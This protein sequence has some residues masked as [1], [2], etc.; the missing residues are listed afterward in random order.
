MI[1]RLVDFII[2]ILYLFR[3]YTILAPYQKGVKIRF[4]KFNKALE[5]GPVFFLPFKLDQVLIENAVTETLNTSPQSLTTKDGVGVVISS[6]VTF[7]IEDIKTFLLCVEGRNNVVEDCTYGAISSFILS[8]TWPELQ[9]MDLANEI[10]KVVRRS[11]KKYGVE[12]VSVQLS[13]F[14]RCKSIRL[15]GTVIK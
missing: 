5:P 12:I 1:D 3:F 4:G 9:T 14:S 8:R 6:V 7:N 11:A 13:D 2:S 10:S 15:L